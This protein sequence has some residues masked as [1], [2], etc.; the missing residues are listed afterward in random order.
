MT[1][2]RIVT[3]FLWLTACLLIVSYAG[4]EKETTSPEGGPE[5][6]TLSHLAKIYEPVP[7]SHEMHTLVTEGCASCHHH[8]PE[9]ETPSCGECHNPSSVKDLGIAGLKEAYHG[10]CMG[11]H[12][13]MEVGPTGCTECHAK[14]TKK[15]PPKIQPTAEKKS[16]TGPE[17]LTLS[18]LE[19]KYEAVIFSHE[20][21]NLITEDCATCHHH[22]PAGQTPSCDKCH[23]A[24]FDP[25]NLNMPGLKGAYHLQ[26][27]GCHKET[28][29][30]AGCTECHAK[31]DS[32]KGESKEK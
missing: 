13:E 12:K 4:G 15:S 27:V 17:T 25:E 23:D 28:G 20:I 22:S 1:R 7:F 30:P 11:C 3:V 2:K 26:C 9:G 29:A 21:H 24:P 6:L 8:S 10:K 31:K 32:K 16:K 18:R 5:T 19:K 14:L